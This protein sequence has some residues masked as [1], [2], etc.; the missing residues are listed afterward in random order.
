[1]DAGVHTGSRLL[2]G[3]SIRPMISYVGLTWGDGVIREGVNGADRQLVGRGCRVGL[4]VPW[5]LHECTRRSGV[6]D[7]D[8]MV[9]ESG[10]THTLGSCLC[11]CRCPPYGLGHM[12][13]DARKAPYLSL[14]V[15]GLSTERGSGGCERK[16]QRQQQG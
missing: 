8:A 9:V 14:G 7:R 13:Q 4:D 6:S 5:V 15:A 16:E 2:E 10:Y 11:Y 12:C 3:S 1:M